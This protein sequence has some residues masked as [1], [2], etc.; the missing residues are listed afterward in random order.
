[1]PIINNIG[2]ISYVLVAVAGS[3]LLMFNVPNLSITGSAFTL[4]IAVSFLNITKQFTGNINQVSGQINS[5]V[6]G[7]AGIK[8]VFELI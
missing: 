3:I 8:R 6:M 5:I 4:G 2:N 7:F 1:M